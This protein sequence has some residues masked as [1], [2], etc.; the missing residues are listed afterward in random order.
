MKTYFNNLKKAKEFATL[1]KYFTFPML[2]VF[3]REI[4]EYENST[5]EQSENSS[6]SGIIEWWEGLIDIITLIDIYDCKDMVIYPSFNENLSEDNTYELR[7]FDPLTLSDQLF[8]ANDGY[9]KEFEIIDE[10][11][12]WIAYNIYPEVM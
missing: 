3:E 8:Y 5:K 1:V 2:I 10:A 7:I 11:W 4:D 6:H 9:C 12:N